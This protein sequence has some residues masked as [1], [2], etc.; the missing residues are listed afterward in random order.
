MSHANTSLDV[1]TKVVSTHLYVSFDTDHLIIRQITARRP[2]GHAAGILNAKHSSV[3]GLMRT[4]LCAPSAREN[5]E[6]AGHVIVNLRRLQTERS[7]ALPLPSPQRV[8]TQELP[9]PNT[10]SDG[11]G[12]P[13]ARLL[14]V[15]AEAILG[16]GLSAGR[17]PY[18]KQLVSVHP[19]GT[20]ISSG[21]MSSVG[22]LARGP[23]ACQREAANT[24]EQTRAGHVEARA[25][26]KVG[27]W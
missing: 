26:Q 20:A 21:S 17:Y 5:M 19:L 11:C 9:H 13:S 10:H 7:T 24:H 1:A 16:P 22:M 4:L 25:L 14:I 23:P 27:I 15:I 8:V 18:T 3:L 2:F 12:F 6:T